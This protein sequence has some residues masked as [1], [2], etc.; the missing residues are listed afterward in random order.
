MPAPGTP[1]RMTT[2]NAHSDCFK[3][4]PRTPIQPKSARPP[5]PT[6]PKFTPTRKPG[7]APFE[8]KSIVNKINKNNS[9]SPTNTKSKPESNS[10]KASDSKIKESDSCILEVCDELKNSHQKP[11]ELD[12]LDSTSD[13]PTNSPP[14]TLPKLDIPTSVRAA[15]GPNW[16]LK[17]GILNSYHFGAPSVR[18]TDFARSKLD[19]K[20]ADIIANPHFSMDAK[21]HAVKL[22]LGE[23]LN[24]TILI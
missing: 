14:R 22:F 9:I 11:M 3:S 4:S 17:E 19:I 6:K 18:P 24:L 20:T 1:K 15:V 2:R 12:E 16:R 13:V 21:K 23:I 7:Q 5:K 8:V 10:P